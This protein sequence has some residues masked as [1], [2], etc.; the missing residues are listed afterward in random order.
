MRKDETASLDSPA[1]GARD[2]APRLTGA[3]AV[4]APV[5]GSASGS[6]GDA[7]G[8]LARIQ[9]RL[10]TL[11]ASS[12][13]VA[14]FVLTNPWQARGLS[15][16]DL[17]A[18][19]GVSINTVNRMARL[20]D[21]RGYREFAQAL[22][23]DLGRILGSAYSL[24]VSIAAEEATGGA[25][26]ALTLVSRTLAL[27]VQAIQ[28]TVRHL[29]AKA[30]ERAVRA[31]ATARAVVFAGT[32]SGYPVCALA[33]YR[34]VVLGVRASSSAD[35]SA[36]MAEIHL[37]EPG[38]VIFAVSH[39]GGTRH[40]AQMLGHARERGLVALCLTAAPGSP[41][42]QAADVALVTYG[43]TFGPEGG[44]VSG[45]FASRVVSTAVI[46]G[47]LAAATWRRYGAIPP[48]VETLLRAQQ[49]LTVVSPEDRR[50]SP[51]AG[52]KAMA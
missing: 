19:A 23:L 38:D 9:Q 51:R 39:H 25:A 49:A 48:R 33:A 50:R 28:E 16:G 29:D 15:I 27:E 43:E 40:L 41:V 13:R 26:S 30:V 2:A 47:L 21:Y 8:V 35:P 7:V 10:T 31:L 20:L 18:K 46:E 4:G 1:A 24:P 44:A 17:A 12:R 52:R 3:E 36:I 6:V 32:G 45:Q 34:L 14:E 11:N 22:A 5:N 37:L 42:A